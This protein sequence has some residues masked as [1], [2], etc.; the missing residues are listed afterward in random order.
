MNL[1]LMRL[2]GEGA[3][4]SNLPLYRRTMPSHKP[5]AGQLQSFLHVPGLQQSRVTIGSAAKGGSVVPST[6]NS[7]RELIGRNQEG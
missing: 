5:T 4:K 2:G 7:M 6:N 1:L 3:T